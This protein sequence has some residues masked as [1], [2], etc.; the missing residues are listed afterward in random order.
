MKAVFRRRKGSLV[1]DEILQ[2][3]YGIFDH[4]DIVGFSRRVFFFKP[5][6][7]LSVGFNS[8]IGAGKFEINVLL[9]SFFFPL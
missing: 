4:N 9:N 8:S 2:I 5:I 3:T 1:D 6:F 7:T